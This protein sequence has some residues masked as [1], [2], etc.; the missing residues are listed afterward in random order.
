MVTSLAAPQEKIR[1]VSAG[2]E[3]K[4]SLLL[5]LNRRGQAVSIYK[6]LVERNPDHYQVGS[7]DLTGYFKPLLIC[8]VSHGSCKAFC[9]RD[10]K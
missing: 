4:A 9:N 6:E 1:D 3:L 7:C 5:K 8:T 2:L 10:L